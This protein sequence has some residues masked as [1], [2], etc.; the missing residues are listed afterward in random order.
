MDAKKLFLPVSAVLGLV[1]VVFAFGTSWASQLSDLRNQD[2]RITK[3]EIAVQNISTAL[4]DVTKSNIALQV[5]VENLT[6]KISGIAS[7]VKD[8]RTMVK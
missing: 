4:N 2:T 3:L 1:A 6:D 7:D 8:I 5:G